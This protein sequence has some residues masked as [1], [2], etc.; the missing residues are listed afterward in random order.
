MTS[1][2]PRVIRKILHELNL[3][4]EEEIQQF[5]YPQLDTLPHP[6]Q[7][8]GM[9]EAVNI[10][11]Q[12]IEKGA[13]IIIWG[14]Y[15][16]DGTTA[17]SLLINF[18]RELGIE[19]HWHIPNRLIDGY[20]LNSQTF[21]KLHQSIG[22]GEFILITVDCGISNGNEINDILSLGG[23]VIVTDHHQLPLS[24]LPGCVVLNPN[25]DGCSFKKERLAGVGVAF[26]LAAAL[27]TSLDRVG[28]FAQLKKPNMKEYLGFVALG[29]ISDLVEI[30]P[31]N[32]VLVRAGMET[33]ARSTIPG[34][35]SLM[36]S[37]GLCCGDLT[38]EDI[39][40]GLGPRINAA[41]RLGEA[42]VAV[43]L[44]TCDNDEAGGLLSRKL[45]TFNDRRK[46]LCDDN[47]EIALTRVASSRS[48]I[49]A[50]SAI[51]VEGD[52]HIGIMGIVASKLVD[53]YR[54]PAIV[55]AAGE[56]GESCGPMKGSGR[57]IPGVNLLECLHASSAKIEK[58]GGHAMAAGLTVNKDNFSDF[59]KIFN[60]N[61]TIAKM[62]SEHTPQQNEVIVDCSV[63]EIMGSSALDY[64]IKL[65]P[66]GPENTKPLF[67]DNNAM[68][69]NCKAIGA[70]GQHLQLVVRG[71]FENYRGVGF[72]L[73]DRYKE[74]KK[75]PERRVLFSPMVN[76]FRGQFEWQLR[77][78]D[79]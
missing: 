51:V 47:L 78:V 19:T 41:G 27:R 39:S 33:L 73:G 66:F 42:A 46:K 5:L 31:T 76:R 30:T 2:I 11:T 64:Y 63:D 16:V 71:K 57:S 25:Q 61:V 50:S 62:N 36:N 1:D 70:N 20:G 9:A 60:D 53:I 55:F 23:Q 59:K 24:G 22:G 45:E 29:T 72:G 79:I 58:Y 69:V 48:S 28:Y 8:K 40:F 34:I 17:T 56:L 49:D 26:Y 35:R 15:D 3:R 38:S 67:S 75:N 6:K 43:Q 68:V 21:Q 14:D 52:F 77:V 44:M 12:G 32:R 37:A 13:E 65:E 4:G 7:M 18:F 74:V 10:I 54:K